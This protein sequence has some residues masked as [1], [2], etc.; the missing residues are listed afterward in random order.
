MLPDI[1]LSFCRHLFSLTI[2]FNADFIVACFLNNT[3]NA[4]FFSSYFLTN[5][6]NAVCFVATCFLAKD[7]MQLYR[8]LSFVCVHLSF[9]FFF[10]FTNSLNADLIVASFL[11]NF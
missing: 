10:F 11:T 2:V 7:L 8:H 9:F 3:F 6:F 4:F 5:S 1:Q